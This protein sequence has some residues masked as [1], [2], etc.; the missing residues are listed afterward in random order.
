MS[1]GPSR[2]LPC[3]LLL[4]IVPQCRDAHKR[5]TTGSEIHPRNDPT[6]TAGS[7]SM[8]V[9]RRAGSGP[10][11]LQRMVRPLLPYA[12]RRQPLAGQQRDVAGRE[13]TVPQPGEGTGR[14]PVALD[15]P[16]AGK[17]TEVRRRHRRRRRVRRFWNWRMGRRVR[18]MRH[19]WPRGI[20]C[21]D[22]CVGGP[23]RPVCAMQASKC[24]R[25]ARTSLTTGSGR[26]QSRLQTPERSPASIRYL[27]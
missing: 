13:V 5:A 4:A 12:P 9:H 22:P 14:L 18:E 10:V 3:D 16:E 8:A 19:G 25:T 27:S 20:R 15:A 1:P 21:R 6:Q 2:Y 24:D 17:G 11:S 26:R 7:S 23:N